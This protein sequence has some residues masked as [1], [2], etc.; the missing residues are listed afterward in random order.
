M[1]VSLDGGQT[2]VADDGTTTP[3]F[4]QARD[5]T[6]VPP[7]V[8]HGTTAPTV[9]LAPNLYFTVYVAGPHPGLSNTIKGVRWRLGP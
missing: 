8:G 5:S 6:L 9:Q 2:W 3:R 4:N 1:N 7:R